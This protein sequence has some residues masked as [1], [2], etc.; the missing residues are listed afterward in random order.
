[1]VKLG[2]LVSS[3]NQV[4]VFRLQDKLGKQNFHADIKIVFE[5]AT[6]S[7]KD[8]SEE[9]TKGMIEN[10]I[11]N[12]KTMKNL[13]IKLL[14]I[15]NDGGLLATYLMSPLYKITNLENYSQFNLVKVS[16]SNR[17]NDWKKKQDNTNYAI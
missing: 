4:K 11:R 1:M 7:I 12:I 3:E 14:K 6:K 8:V 13:N 15:I 16:N 17:R 5:P 2:K 9:V 10:S